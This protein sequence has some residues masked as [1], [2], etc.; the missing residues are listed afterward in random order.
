MLQRLQYPQSFINRSACHQDNSFRRTTQHSGP[1]FQLNAV[2]TRHIPIRLLKLPTL[3]SL[4][5][6]RREDAL[7]VAYPA[8][9]PIR[10]TLCA[11]DDGD[12]FAFLETKIA[13]LVC[14]ECELRNRLAGSCAAAFVTEGRFGCAWPAWS[15]AL[16]V[17]VYVV[18]LV[19]ECGGA[20][21]AGFE[22]IESLGGVCAGEAVAGLVVGVVLPC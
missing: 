21:A 16:A 5:V 2:L 1:K 6:V 14:V 12:D 15:G 22:T 10:F 4:Y 18:A 9:P 3:N 17:R 8:R 19:T 20:A 7:P 11:L 13:R